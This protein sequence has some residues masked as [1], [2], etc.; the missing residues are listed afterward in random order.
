MGGGEHQGGAARLRRRV[1]GRAAAASRAAPADV[2]VTDG[3][4]HVRGVPTRFMTLKDIAGWAA[5]AERTD[6][7]AVKA[8]F[9]PPDTVF[10]FGAHLAYVEVDPETRPAKGLRYVAGDDCGPGIHPM[11]CE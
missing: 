3:R 2:V 6:E 11:N 5:G 7:L 10:P 1:G 8:S 9:D 4:V